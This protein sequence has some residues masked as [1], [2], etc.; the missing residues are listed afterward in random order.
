MNRQGKNFVK[1]S[2]RNT[3]SAQKVLRFRNSCI[4]RCSDLASL[5][6]YFQIFHTFSKP[7]FLGC[8]YVNSQLNPLADT[9][10]YVVLQTW[11]KIERDL[12]QMLANKADPAAI[13]SFSQSLTSIL[14]SNYTMN[15]TSGNFFDYKRQ[16]RHSQDIKLTCIHS[17]HLLKQLKLSSLGGR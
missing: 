6:I 16:S 15:Y 17:P 12:K 10:N 4:L 3:I 8:H 2:K 11:K 5:T 9:S 14:N 1:L 13:Y 7:V